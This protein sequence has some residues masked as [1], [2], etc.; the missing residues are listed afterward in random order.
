MANKKISQLSV[1]GKLL[2]GDLIPVARSGTNVS[3]LGSD[4]LG[5]TLPTGGSAGQVLRKSDDGAVWSDASGITGLPYLFTGPGKYQYWRVSVKS[6]TENTTAL[7]EIILS[8]GATGVMPVIANRT[9]NWPIAWTDGNPETGAGVATFSNYATETFDFGTAVSIDT[10]RLNGLPTVSLMKVE[11][12]ADQT[13]WYNAYN[14]AVSLVEHVEKAFPLTIQYDTYQTTYNLTADPTKNVG[15]ILKVNAD[16]TGFDFTPALPT[17]GTTGQLLRVGENGNLFWS[18]ETA[19]PSGLSYLSTT[20]NKYRY[21]RIGLASDRANYTWM[22]NVDLRTPND[23]IPTY[24][25]QQGEFPI[26]W[27][28]GNT[29]SEAYI[30]SSEKFNYNTFDYGVPVLLT[31]LTIISG[32]NP[33]YGTRYTVLVSNNGVDFTPVAAGAFWHTP[34]MQNDPNAGFNTPGVPNQYN[35]A[36]FNLPGFIGGIGYNLSADPTAN[37]GKVLKVNAAGTGFDFAEVGAGPKGD[38]GDIGPQGPAGPAGSGGTGSGGAV[39]VVGGGTT[40]HT[41]RGELT[42]MAANT[43]TT[44]TTLTFTGQTGS[45]RIVSVNEYTR[46]AMDSGQFGANQMTWKLYRNDVVYLTWHTGAE[47]V[48]PHDESPSF[49][50]DS[51]DLG[52]TSITYRMTASYTLAASA[53]FGASLS[54]VELLPAAPA[55]V[56]SGKVK[57]Y[58]NSNTITTI[59]P[60]G[61]EA[62]SVT[63]TPRAGS[64]ID[65]SL[66][67]I[68]PTVINVPQ[69]PSGTYSQIET[70]VY[71]NGV[72]ITNQVNMDTVTASIPLSGNFVEENSGTDPITFRVVKVWAIYDNAKNFMRYDTRTGT[73][74]YSYKFIEYP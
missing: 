16:G 67:G 32:S 10:I 55:P 63:F 22:Y 50:V 1:G 28:D 43:E 51:D 56:S 30:L 26:A 21:Y 14:G 61:T 8:R 40:V 4:L 38:K 62:Y 69:S 13:T 3:V 6:E 45:Q 71:R 52:A 27:L 15:K 44:V 31:K 29:T 37:I 53:A 57:I 46:F 66:G 60:S 12:S 7:W 39:T 34:N 65:F 19:T 74:T 36:T 17:N 70:R 18:T 68:Q 48:R 11:Y 41:A 24:V 73:F 25:S 54:V 72:L 35:S 49:L 23:T 2:P 33:A 64:T 42:S 59:D 20:D 9:T 5:S 47:S 58:Q